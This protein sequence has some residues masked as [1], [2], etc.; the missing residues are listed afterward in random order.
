MQAVTSRECFG[1]FFRSDDSLQGEFF[2]F[3]ATQ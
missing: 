3:I 1:L 2:A